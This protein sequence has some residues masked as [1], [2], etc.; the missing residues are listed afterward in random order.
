MKKHF[1]LYNLYDILHFRMKRNFSLLLILLLVLSSALAEQ[2]TISC[3]IDADAPQKS[4][5]SWMSNGKT[6]KDF[7]DATSGASKKHSLK[8][9]NN[10]IKKNGRNCFP[11]S[12]QN[13]L[14]FAVS[15]PEYLTEDALSFS[16]TEKTI[17]IQF[18]HRGNAYKIVTEPDGSIDFTSGCFVHKNIAKNTGGVFTID[19]NF[20]KESASE[21]K[22]ADPHDFSSVDWEK[23]SF[24]PDKPEASSE[25]G[26]KGKLRATVSQ[27]AL[28][29]NGT[30]IKSDNEKNKESVPE[31]GLFGAI[32]EKI[33][34]L[35][36]KTAEE[37]TPS[38]TEVVKEEPAT[39]EEAEEEDE[40]AESG[41]Q[42]E[43]TTDSGTK[44][45]ENDN[46]ESDDDS[47]AISPGKIDDM[48]RK[49]DSIK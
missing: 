16:K 8:E 11:K 34:G 20:L 36:K 21:E 30:L 35:R 13:L 17:T 5:F 49:L 19:E 41:G 37:K 7:F 23:L 26:F 27:N 43:E 33:K 40:S 46:E 10:V 15:S 18:I 31:T 28:K 32:K 29:I 44:D 6:T 1:T 14:L 48:L 47:T 24:T 22:K 45:K 38:K 4:F 25:Q 39:E 2:L 42:P 12:V 9:F 3:L